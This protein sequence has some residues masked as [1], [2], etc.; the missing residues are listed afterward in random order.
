MSQDK[1]AEQVLRFAGTPAEYWPGGSQPDH[2]NALQV[3]AV[4]YDPRPGAGPLELV[5]LLLAPDGNPETTAH[6]YAD[7]GT[8]AAHWGRPQPFS[9]PMDP[10]TARQVFRHYAALHSTPPG[11]ETQ[12]TTDLRT[13]PPPR[14][15]KLNA[16]RM[17]AALESAVHA[18]AA[19]GL[20]DRQ[21]VEMACGG[22]RRHDLLERARSRNT[23]ETRLDIENRLARP[24]PEAP[25]WP[26]VTDSPDTEAAMAS[27]IASAA[28]ASHW[29]AAVEMGPDGHANRRS[30]T[31]TIRS[32]DGAE[33][34]I[35]VST[36]R[37]PTPMDLGEVS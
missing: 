34:I 33:R 11:Q 3:Y 2:E 37:Q 32:K 5:S 36:A 26:A 18:A 31:V 1:L 19:A 12:G 20:L 21:T 35:A 24:A 29:C 27:W 30:H 14:Y 22:L 9:H 6:I 15:P 16:E 23:P 13:A 4:T 10:D 7:R 8:I 17:M 28:L 25:P